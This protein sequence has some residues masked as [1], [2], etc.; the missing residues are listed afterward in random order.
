[1][2][3][4][5]R[6]FLGYD[7]SRA[8]PNIVVDGSPNESTV[9][10]LSHWPGMA[11]PAGTSVDTSAE[12]AFAYLDRPLDDEPASVVT[13][14]HFDQDGAAGIFALISPVEALAHRELLIDLARAGD[15]GTYRLRNA[16]RASMILNGLSD[17]SQPLTTAN[18]CVDA[19]ADTAALYE[20]ALPRLIEMLTD[21]APYLDLWGAEDEV[22]SESEQAIT[23]GHVQITEHP[24]LDLAVVE[25]D[26]GQPRR[27]GHRFGHMQVGPIH[28]MA[29]NNAT[30]CS[31]ILMI[32][33]RRFSYVDRYETWVQVHTTSPPQRV[34]LR[35][36]A[37][38]LSAAEDGSTTWSSGEPSGLTPT[39]V[40]DGESSLDPEAV[41]TRVRAHLATAPP[42]WDPYDVA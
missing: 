18:L 17:E 10:T 42:A 36:L 16:A 9:L 34:D 27:V 4:P 22:L 26:A 5:P 1:M 7:E 32:H 38:T 24:D 29:V 28:Q 23:D 40:H 8:V 11:Q 31:R 25:I 14:N 15:F 39:L 12:M 6:T 19:G 2:S 37:Q 33:G 35:P 13:N 21:P 20:G 41:V 3:L 30:D